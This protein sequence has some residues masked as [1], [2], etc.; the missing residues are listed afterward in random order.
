MKREIEEKEAGNGKGINGLNFIFTK[1]GCILIVY[2]SRC[3]CAVCFLSVSVNSNILETFYKKCMKDNET[4]AAT[5]FVF[6]GLLQLSC[7]YLYLEDV[8]NRV[9]KTIYVFNTIVQTGIFIITHM[10]DK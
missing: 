7:I 4:K 3:P 2:F 1:Q 6:F 8:L 5:I 9:S 10:F